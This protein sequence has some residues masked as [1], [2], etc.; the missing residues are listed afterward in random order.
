M[1]IGDLIRANATDPGRAQRVFLHFNDWQCTFAQYHEE[2]SRWARLMLTVAGASAAPF[3]VG[4][5]LDN[6]PDYFFALGGA[7]LAGAVVSGI[8]NTKRG[9]HLARDIAYTDCR[10]L[11]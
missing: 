2:C 6:L 3:H 1:P 8:N 5:L 7:A 10:I 11:V 4:I 9:S